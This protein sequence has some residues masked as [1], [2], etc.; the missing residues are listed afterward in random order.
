MEAPFTLARGPATATISNASPNT[1]KVVFTFDSRTPPSHRIAST[2][3]P[4]LH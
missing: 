1:S 3:H 2:P 4:L